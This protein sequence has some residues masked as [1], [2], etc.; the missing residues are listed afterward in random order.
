MS[1]VPL[2][3]DQNRTAL[4]SGIQRAGRIIVLIQRQATRLLQTVATG[5]QFPNVN[6]RLHRYCFVTANCFPSEVPL[7]PITSASAQFVIRLG[8]L[9]AWPVLVSTLISQRLLSPPHSRRF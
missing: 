9:T 6:I 5:F 1:H 2:R 3:S 4:L 7:K 8:L